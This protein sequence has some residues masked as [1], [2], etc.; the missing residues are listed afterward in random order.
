MSSARAVLSGPGG[1]FRRAPA[2]SPLAPQAASA[3]YVR[4]RCERFHPTISRVQQSITLTRDAQPTVGPA[5][6]LVISDLPDLIRSCC[7]HATPLFLSSGAQV[8]R[9]NQ[10]AS[11]A[12]HPQ[13][14]FAIHAKPF[15][16]PQP[17]VSRR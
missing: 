5:Q 13:H 2:G 17:P 14:S 7:F 12:H 4:Q 11:L 10:Q 6:I 8:P 9:A 1:Q 3:S 15:L 16:P